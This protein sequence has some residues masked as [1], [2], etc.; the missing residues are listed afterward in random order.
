MVKSIC[1]RR[2]DNASTSW[3]MSGGNVD[4]DVEGMREEDWLVIREVRGVDSGSSSVANVLVMLED[5]AE[6]EG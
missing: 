5:V 3:D 6:E 2:R 1:R 4:S